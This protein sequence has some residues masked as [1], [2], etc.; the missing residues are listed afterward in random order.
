ME[1]WERL[2]TEIWV[3]VYDRV[4]G[5]SGLGLILLHLFVIDLSLQ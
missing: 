3:R 4:F 5:M 2:A 1:K